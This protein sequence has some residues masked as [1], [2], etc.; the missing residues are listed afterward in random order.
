[1]LS[2]A[3]MLAFPD[4][5]KE[6]C[7]YTDASEHSWG[8]VLTQMPRDYIGKKLEEQ[9]HEPLFFLGGQF[10][11]SS[12]HWAIIEKEAFAI[13]ESCTRLDYLLQ[14]EAGFR[15]YADHKNLVY[16]FDPQYRPAAVKK[17]TEEKLQHWALR[18]NASSAINRSSRTNRVSAL[19]D[20]AVPPQN[21]VSGVACPQKP[22]HVCHF[23]FI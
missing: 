3:C 2:N 18:L 11:A 22:R 1:M 15:I 14:R 19:V 20:P 4:P 21:W 10:K 5:Q 17:F 23:L 12:R 8:A 9:R 16:L 6:F 13:V 7:L